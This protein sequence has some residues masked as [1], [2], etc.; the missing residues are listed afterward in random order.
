MSLS[1][2]LVSRRL[3]LGGAATAGAV[4]LAA[5]APAWAK[6][7]KIEYPFTLGVA[8]GD[9][10]PT[11]IV[12]WTRLA[13]KPFDGGHG[14]RGLDAVPVRW[15]VATDAGMTRVVAEGTTTTFD[16]WAH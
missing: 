16:V 4:A 12:L 5:P 9:P 13:P 8:S 10:E 11:A 2:S 6:P 15:Q 7:V 1:E 3:V 14:M